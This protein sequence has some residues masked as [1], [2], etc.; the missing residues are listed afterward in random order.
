M[1]QHSCSCSVVQSTFDLGKEKEEEE[2]EEKEEEEEEGE[3]EEEFF[4][5]ILRFSTAHLTHKST[6]KIPC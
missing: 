4:S 5:S 6:R 1:H 3:E 2:E